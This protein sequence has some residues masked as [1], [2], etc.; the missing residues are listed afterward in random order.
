M[1]VHKSKGLEF[2]IVILADMTAKLRA[3]VASRTIDSD[4]RVCAI[5]LG[6]WAPAD[7]LQHEDE[8][9]RRDEAEGTRVAY[10]AA[11]RART[12]SWSPQWAMSKGKAGPS[13]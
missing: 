7:L 12:Y 1:T 2:P 5:R 9:L 8:E 6:G 3:S 4:R 10:V 13:R 11:T